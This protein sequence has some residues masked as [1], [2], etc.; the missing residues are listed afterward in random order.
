[1]TI[2]RAVRLSES[3]SKKLG[4]STT[5]RPR[6]VLSRRQLYAGWQLRR[7]ATT[8]Q[9]ERKADGERRTE[10]NKWCIIA[11]RTSLGT[12]CS[13]CFKEDEGVYAKYSSITALHKFISLR[14]QI[15]LQHSTLPHAYEWIHYIKAFSMY[16]LLLRE[17]F[18]FLTSP[19][20]SQFCFASARF[21]IQ[22]NKWYDARTYTYIYLRYT[23]ED[24]LQ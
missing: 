17:S 20:L 6:R 8:P 24:I 13:G 5:G 3:R 12:Q 11:R 23:F 16:N 22:G 18:Q 7:S 14:H 1:M 21:P 4:D 2:A 15:L 9:D 10:N 19:S